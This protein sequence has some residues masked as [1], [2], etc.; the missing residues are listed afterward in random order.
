MSLLKNSANSA[1]RVIYST[2]GSC[3]TIRRP[4][5]G[6]VATHLLGCT[7]V[8]SSLFMPPPP[9]KAASAL[10]MATAVVATALVQASALPSARLRALSPPEPSPAAPHKDVVT[11]RK[12]DLATAAAFPEGQRNQFQASATAHRGVWIWGR[13]MA[14]AQVAQAAVSWQHTASRPQILES[15]RESKSHRCQCHDQV[16]PGCII[17]TPDGCILFRALVLK[18]AHP[19]RLGMSQRAAKD[20]VADR[21]YACKCICLGA[22]ED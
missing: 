21:L 9:R 1:Y 10:R 8:A 18:Y 20:R 22:N 3:K 19:P 7:T 14:S 4:M 17:M 12:L 15:I 6:T 5:L 2:C 11:E 16:S 13:S